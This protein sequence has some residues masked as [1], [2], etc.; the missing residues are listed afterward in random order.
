MSASAAIRRFNRDRRC[1]ICD[2]CERDPRGKGIRCTGW[3][4]DD[5]YA[6]ASAKPA[7]ACSACASG[8]RCKRLGHMEAKLTRAR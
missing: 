4:S 7:Q 5:E 8:L 1:P 3:Q 2:G 6:Q